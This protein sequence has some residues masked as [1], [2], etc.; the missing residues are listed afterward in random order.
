ML[1]V[2]AAR[3]ALGLEME[4]VSAEMLAAM[5]RRRRSVTVDEL[6]SDERLALAK[7]RRGGGWVAVEEERRQEARE[8]R[9]RLAIEQKVRARRWRAEGTLSG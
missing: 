2:D 6:Q 7:W 4:D 9:A 5:R 3:V 1:H 8:A